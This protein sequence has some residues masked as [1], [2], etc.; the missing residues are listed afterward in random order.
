[1]K[2]CIL[3]FSILLC[4]FVS[5]FAQNE[6][7]EGQVSLLRKYD[8]VLGVES[9]M[10]NSYEFQ[11]KEYPSEIPVSEYGAI[12]L[13][14][15]FEGYEKIASQDNPDAFYALGHFFRKTEY[16]YKHHEIAFKIF[17]ALDQVG[18]VPGTHSLGYLYAEGLG[19]ERDI[20]KA[21]ACYEK[22]IEKKYSRSYVNLAYIYFDGNGVPKNLEKAFALINEGI[23]YFDEAEGSVILADMYVQYAPSYENLRKAEDLYRVAENLGNKEVYRKFA[24]LYDSEGPM[25][26]DEKEAVYFRKMVEHDAARGLET[27]QRD[28]ELLV[29]LLE[30]EKNGAKD[31]YDR[32]AAIYAPYG[33][34]KPD[35]KKY[36]EYLLKAAEQGNAASMVTVGNA[37]SEGDYF[38]ADKA[39][40]AYWLSKAYE[41]NPEMKMTIYYLIKIYRES[42][43]GLGSYL[44]T[45]IENFYAIGDGGFWEDFSGVKPE[46][47]FKF[48][49]SFAEREVVFPWLEKEKLEA[50]YSV[51]YCYANGIGTEQN[52]ELALQYGYVEPDKKIR[53]A[54][55]YSAEKAEW[56]HEKEEELNELLEK[57]N[58]N[59]ATS[60]DYYELAQ[61]ITD[62]SSWSSL[63]KAYPYLV[64]ACEMDNTAALCL[65]ASW[66]K[67]GRYVESSAERSAELYL[68]AAELGD[69][70]AIECVKNLYHYGF[71]VEQSCD[72][73]IEWALKRDPKRVYDR[74]VER[75]LLDSQIPASNK[76]K[77]SKNWWEEESV[78]SESLTVESDEE[79][80]PDFFD[81]EISKHSKY[82]APKDLTD[83]AEVLAA[84]LSSFLSGGEEWKE[85]VDADYDD[86]ELEKETYGKFYEYRE[87]FLD[88]FKE[89]DF[90]FNKIS[91]VSR[92]SGFI[93]IRVYIYLETLDGEQEDGYDEV[94]MYYRNDTDRWYVE[95]LPQ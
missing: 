19:T 6:N 56:L 39:K 58:S 81:F 62:N 3:S 29:N 28:N 44:K 84:F 91:D 61:K 73:E 49:K 65:L 18:Y 75:Y 2:K 55:E 88:Q 37:Y 50:F 22:A 43:I 52:M 23:K 13:T 94:S 60:R 11:G 8:A 27:R 78:L 10:K 5:S 14:Q 24:Y 16:I 34:T 87:L 80:K 93:D 72:K 70:W 42:I 54:E 83:P 26:D 86:E 40:A 77:P 59:Q 76:T 46:D 92:K 20:Q 30:Q 47:A 68:R 85:F 4:C 31:S 53:T 41:T 89:I 90:A 1:M 67:E 45:R 82:S 12:T 66:Y 57:A 64:M 48:Y 63:E 71:G 35:Y 33:R 21:I 17:N 32:I 51:G 25:P 9:T 74:D 79:S 7:S 38:Q 36:Y 69:Q 95:E 15:A